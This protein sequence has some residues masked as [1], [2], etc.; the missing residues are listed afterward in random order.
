MG[1]WHHDVYEECYDRK[2]KAYF[3]NN[4][5]ASYYERDDQYTVEVSMEEPFYW[6]W[7][8]LYFENG[9]VVEVCHIETT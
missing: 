8:G 1:I 5:Y 2:L 7:A 4:P 3:K 9:K 6:Y